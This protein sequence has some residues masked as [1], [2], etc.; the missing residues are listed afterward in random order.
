MG[1]GKSVVYDEDW[2][3][4][5]GRNVTG[6]NPISSGFSSGGISFELCKLLTLHVLNPVKSIFNEG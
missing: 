2:K 6:S 1:L 5:R 4:M 3:I